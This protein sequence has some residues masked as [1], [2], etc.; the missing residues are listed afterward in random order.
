MPKLICALLICAVSLSLAG[1]CATRHCEEAGQAVAK[2]HFR[3]AS[4][5]AALTGQAPSQPAD[6]LVLSGGGSH[7][8]WGAGVLRGWRDHADQAR[9]RKFQVVTGV[10]TGALLATHAFLG[11]PG[12]DDLLEEAYTTVKTRDIYGLK[13]L[14]FALLS[15]SLKSS[16][17]LKHRISRHITAETLQRVARIGRGEQRR[18]YAGTVNYDTGKLVIWDLTAIAMDDTNP[19][20]LELYRQVVLASASIPILVPPVKID[21]NLYADGGARAQLFFE[22]GLLPN[23]REVA[24]TNLT[25]YVIVNG[26]L[27]L[28]ANC[29][30]NCLKELTLRTL[31]MLLDANGIGNLYHIKYELDRIGFGRFRLA[32]IPREFPVTSSAVFEPEAMRQLYDEGVR[33]GRQGK[34]E[35][36]IPEVDLRPWL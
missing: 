2:Y 28:E 10:S 34:W 22:S 20:R 32:R 21:G 15:N 7:G 17:P 6:I 33:F 12:D 29:V 27:G 23:L 3:P 26:K 13:L 18:L 16:A 11:E 19:D 1:C 36:Q 5:R 24:R 9:P 30:S 31:D 14:P 25:L 4:V 35:R 8:A